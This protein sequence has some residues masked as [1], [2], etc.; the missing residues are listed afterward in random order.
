LLLFPV[1][2]HA[3]DEAH[4]REGSGVGNIQ[5]Q[6]LGKAAFGVVRSLGLVLRCGLSHHFLR[7]TGQ[8]S[9]KLPCG[10]ETLL[11]H[12]R[13]FRHGHKNFEVSGKHKEG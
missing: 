9:S 8:N 10:N 5:H 13:G 2:A 11:L 4:H 3:S 1:V 7:G 12:A 6:P